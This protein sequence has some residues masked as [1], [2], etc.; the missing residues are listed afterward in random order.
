[1]GSKSDR[2]SFM[3]FLAIIGGILIVIVAILDFMGFP[4][5]I[6]VAYGIIWIVIGL[7]ILMSCFKPNDPVPY[8][9]GFILIMGIVT[10]VL[11]FVLE[12]MGL[13]AGFIVA[14]IA[15]I[16]ITIGGFIGILT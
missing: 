15:G 9:E 1:M 3:R 5:L 13:G 12:G 14:L 16:M 11:A 6:S 10:I 7:I 2:D 4:N 8:N